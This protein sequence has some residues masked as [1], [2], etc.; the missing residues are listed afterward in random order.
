MFGRED[1]A[2]RLWAVR[3]SA[4]ALRLLPW[5]NSSVHMQLLPGHL[6]SLSM[7]S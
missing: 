3:Q 6:I 5:K 1:A 7:I 4:G 2:R